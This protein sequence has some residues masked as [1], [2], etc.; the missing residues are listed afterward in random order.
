MSIVVPTFREAPNVSALAR[1]V[2]RAMARSAS[3]WELLLVD[4]DSQDGIDAVV[5]DLSHGLP[6]RLAV[7]RD[8]P[9]DLS[10]SV[11]WG[12]EIARFE[13]LVVLDADL[14][15]PPEAILDLIRALDR[16]CEMAIGSRYVRDGTIP[17]DWTLWN[18]LN[19]QLATALARPLVHC[20]D[21]LSGFFAIDRR[22]LPHPGSLAPV[23]YKVALEIMVRGRLR[24]CE[25]PIRFAKRHAGRSKTNWAQRWKFLRHLG[26]LYKVQHGGTAR[27]ICYG[28]VVAG[29]AFVDLAC[30]LGL[31]WLD[32]EHRVAR[33]VAAGTGTAWNWMRVRGQSAA[34]RTA[35]AEV[36][37]P[38]GGSLSRALAGLGGNAGTYVLLTS[39]VGFCDDHRILTFFLGIAL[40]DVI[41]FL[42]ETVSLSRRRSA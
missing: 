8:E 5:S 6:V 32:W 18:L 9:R 34:G 3:D 14:S 1:R 10:K 27:A 23:G 22:A 38:R 36:L 40:G 11:L 12:F 15:H 30:Y 31:L 13:R 39:F 4:D 7:R 29:A 35:P 41:R 21:P 33:L 20:A 25:V 2:Q 19:S 37:H 26:R 16:G 24:V 17:A 42:W 28:L